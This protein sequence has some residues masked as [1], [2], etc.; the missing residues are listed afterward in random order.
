M[1]GEI[2]VVEFIDYISIL[3][4]LMAEIYMEIVAFSVSSNRIIARKYVINE[5]AV[6]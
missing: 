1:H 6:Q 5:M 3:V 4:W 2:G